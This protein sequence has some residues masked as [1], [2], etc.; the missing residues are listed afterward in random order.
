MWMATITWLLLLLYLGTMAWSW[1]LR[2]LNLRHLRRH[3]TQVPAGFGHVVDEEALRRSSAYTVAQ[4]RVALLESVIDGGLLLAFLFGGLLSWY[5]QWIAALGHTFVASGLLFFLVLSLV[6]TVIDLPFSFYGTFSLEQRY[7]FNTTTKALWLSD[8]LKSTL[9]SLIL[10]GGM[11]AGVY[12]LIS[13][14]PHSWWLWV[15]GLLLVISLVLLYLAPYVI[16]PLF[17][18]YEPIKDEQLD[19]A[20]R[21]LLAKAG[22]QVSRVL[23]VDASRRSRHSNAY[24]TGIGRVKRIVLYDTLL[25]QMDPAEILA[26]LAHEVGH[27]Q[28]GHIWKRLLVTELGMLAACYGGFRLLGWG[29]LPGLLGYGDLSFNGRLVIVGFLASLALFPLTPLASWLSRHHERQA[30]AFAVALCGDSGALAAGLIKLGRENLANLHPHPLYAA[31]Y[32]SHPP[33]VAGTGTA[34]DG[35]CRRENYWMSGLPRT[36]RTGI[37]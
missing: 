35:R 6:Q 20:I 5:D 12:G 25:A 27:W 4:S 28:L 11:L 30:D 7:G 14:S 13:W 17:N 3:G 9:I 37:W 34:G 21:A 8:L 22:L 32:Y 36:P 16:E 15:W 19:A 31:F 26:I 23:Q 24:F 18:K 1:L 10:L 29:E 2:A 33:L